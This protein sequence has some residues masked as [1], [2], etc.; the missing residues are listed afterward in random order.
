[1]PAMESQ[2]PPMRGPA[3]YTQPPRSSYDCTCSEKE[4][5][6]RQQSI[7][8]AR[9]SKSGAGR[10]HDSVISAHPFSPKASSPPSPCSSISSRGRP[11]NSVPETRHSHSLSAT[12]PPQ[13]HVQHPPQA[14]LDPEKHVS[15]SS[16][17]R[18]SPN[19]LSAAV[20]DGDAIVYDKGQYHE[21]GP[22]EKAWH[23]L[24][25]LCGPCAFLS[26]A[27]AIWTACALL[28][29][30]V[31]APLRFCTTRPSMSEQITTFLAPA[32][33]WQLHLVYSHDSTSG[34]S[35]PML[36]VVH[37]FSPV[38]AFGVAIAAWTAAGFWFFS[39]ILGDP[40]GHDGHNDGRESIVGVRN[41]W[42]RWLSRGLR[43]T[44][45]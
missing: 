4:P 43:E 25:W 10:A 22:E 1:M 2:H 5:P 23:L 40:G 28:V 21:K 45:T 24:L 15:R 42:E 34:Y 7:H 39:S 6:Q 44:D 3:T 8:V 38:V 17:G 36:V 27:I 19:R 33:N 14:Y 20:V 41:W 31:L 37:L 29:T 26:G 35:A 18:R 11:H 12:R 32:L 16:Q 13:Q 9:G 30:L